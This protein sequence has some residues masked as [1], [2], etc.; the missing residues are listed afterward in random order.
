M[1]KPI[2]I[3]VFLAFSSGLYADAKPKGKF[4]FQPLFIWGDSEASHQGTGY[5]LKHKNSTYGVTSIHF[6]DFSRGG[7]YHAI[8]CD[9]AEFKP[10]MTFTTS[11]GKPHVKTIANDKDIAFDFV[12]MPAE[13]VPEGYASVEIEVVEK[14]KAGHKI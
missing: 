6:M 12:V 10:V 5:L 4:L 11:L 14:Y 1:I 7:L 9:I 3:V 8:W 13:K 2:F